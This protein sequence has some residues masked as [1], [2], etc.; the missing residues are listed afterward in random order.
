MNLVF[1]NQNKE[2]SIY[3][4]K[5][6]EIAEAQEDKSNLIT[7]AEREGYSTQLDENVS[8][9]CKGNKMVIPKS[10]QHHAIAW[11]HHYLQHFGTKHLDETLCIS[12]D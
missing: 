9:L 10:M 12:M 11:Y 2:D 7:Q 3:L 4:P 8:E 5:T 6:R 1:A